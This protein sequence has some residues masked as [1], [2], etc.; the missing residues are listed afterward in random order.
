MFA[1]VS[2]ESGLYK[3][4]DKGDD[5][6]VIGPVGFERWFSSWRS[7]RKASLRRVVDALPG[8]EYVNL[9]ICE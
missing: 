4:Y 5:W 6:Q 8:A 1:F 3:I 9:V 7:D 2:T